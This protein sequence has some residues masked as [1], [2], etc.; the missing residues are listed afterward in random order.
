MIRFIEQNA[1]TG[2]YYYKSGGWIT[3]NSDRRDEFSEILNKIYLPI[4][5]D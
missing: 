1:E 5:E 2:Q 3:S 4:K